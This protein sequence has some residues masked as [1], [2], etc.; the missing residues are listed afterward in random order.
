MD[1]QHINKKTNSD[2]ASFWSILESLAREE[3][4]A[5]GMNYKILLKDKEELRNGDVF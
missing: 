5:E 2:V 4:L 3:I 1:S